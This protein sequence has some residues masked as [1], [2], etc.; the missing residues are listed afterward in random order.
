VSR[1]LSSKAGTVLLSL[2]AGAT[3]ASAAWWLSTGGDADD[4][5]AGGEVSV[6]FSQGPSGATRLIEDSR[7][8]DDV[9]EAV[10]TEIALPR[11]LEVRVVGDRDA[12]DQGISGP[13]YVPQEHVVY[14]P[15]S[16]VLDSRRELEALSRRTPGFTPKEADE[17]LAAAMQFALYHELAHGII[18][19][20][21][22]PVLAGHERT[23]DSLATVLSL[24]SDERGEALP[25]SIAVLEFA[26]AGTRGAP[27]LAA[28]A[29]DHGLDRQR[30]FDAICAVYGSD[31]EGHDG[32][33][34]GPNALP[35]T[36]AELCPYDYERLVDDWRAVLADHLTSEGTLLPPGFEPPPQRS[37]PGGRDQVEDEL[38]GGQRVAGDGGK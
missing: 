34:S 5:E 7:R 32:L 35:P 25:L 38:H 4:P 21:G 19:A 24:V 1:I 30:A 16:F 31:P 11:D 36:R 6:V 37:H 26:A 15:W 9:V 12:A 13:T 2:V 33:L 17:V 27:T 10:N 20:A 18:D 22:V 23:A 29:D 14:F 3:L 8:F 28:Y